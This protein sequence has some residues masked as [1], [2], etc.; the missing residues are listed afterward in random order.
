M[1][2]TKC[3]LLLLSLGLVSGCVSIQRNT[4]AQMVV[5]NR[6]DVRVRITASEEGIGRGASIRSSRVLGELQANGT[7][8]YTL[9]STW[10]RVSLS[11]EPG[12]QD[13]QTS[14]APQ[15]DRLLKSDQTTSFNG[16]SHGSA[17]STRSD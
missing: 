7:G 6:T 5:L 11:V 2:Y 15:A 8:R 14:D 16:R 1:N 17:A 12:S 3:G 4:G 13:G 9:A 10:R